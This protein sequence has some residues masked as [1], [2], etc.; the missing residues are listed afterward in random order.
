M[1]VSIWR[2]LYRLYINSVRRVRMKIHKILD[3][4]HRALNQHLYS[5]VRTRRLYYFACSTVRRFSSMSIVCMWQW[6]EAEVCV[7]TVMMVVVLS[8]HPAL[9]AGLPSSSTSALA[10]S[11]LCLRTC[12]VLLSV[13]ACYLVSGQRTC[14]TRYR[15]SSWLSPELWRNLRNWNKKY[16]NI[17]ETSTH[18]SNIFAFLLRIFIKSSSTLTQTWPSLRSSA[19]PSS[20]P[21]VA[22]L[23]RWRR[24]AAVDFG[25]TELVRARARARLLC[26]DTGDA[27]P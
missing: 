6:N 13:T 24:A 2:E 20:R 10:S 1:L 25:V 12:G 19:W 22:A 9:C 11:C 26:A 3:I 18:F 8:T 27:E 21:W 23:L 15:K 4:Y 7:D 16:V 14:S 5:M 17:S